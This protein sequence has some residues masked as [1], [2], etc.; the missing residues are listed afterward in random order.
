[1]TR[2][3]A[4]GD[5]RDF[6]YLNTEIYIDT[7]VPLFLTAGIQR[8]ET[9]TFDPETLQPSTGHD[10][11]WDAGI[12]VTPLDGLRVVTRC[13]QGNDYDPNVDIKYVAA[14]GERRWF[15]IGVNLQ[16]P[17]GGDLYWGV[18]ADFFPDRTLRLGAAYENGLDSLWLLAEKFFT[19]R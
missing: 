5:Y 13:Y 15:G 10:T 17:D 6:Q 3:G 4:D 16:K 19:P 9:L 1:A 18:S 11:A 14:A 2:G 7:S 12:G 8:Y